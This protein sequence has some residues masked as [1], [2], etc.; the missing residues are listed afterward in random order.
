MNKKSIALITSLFISVGLWQMFFLSF[1]A[2]SSAEA[3]IRIAVVNFEE[4]SMSYVAFQARLKENDEKKDR[5]VESVTKANEEI[6]RMEKVARQKMESQF[7][8]KFILRVSPDLHQRLSQMARKNR[9]SLNQEVA[10]R[11]EESLG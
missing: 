7:T 11:L 10:S 1:P 8:G 4:V 3:L 5:V 9:R 2:G 6:R